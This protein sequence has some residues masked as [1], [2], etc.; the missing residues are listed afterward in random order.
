MTC[1][2]FSDACTSGRDWFDIDGWW[3]DHRILCWAFIYGN[4][5]NET[6]L[7]QKEQ[8]WLCSYAL[9]VWVLKVHKARLRL[10]KYLLLPGS[11]CMKEDPSSFRFWIESQSAILAFLIQSQNRHRS[12]PV[13][14]AALHIAAP[15]DVLKSPAADPGSS[16]NKSPAVPFR[17]SVLRHAEMQSRAQQCLRSLRM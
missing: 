2:H 5:S 10:A 7:D 16:Q 4:V 15:A 9:N 14:A 3:T 13:K 12:P 8:W 6:M 1:T 17:F 11:R